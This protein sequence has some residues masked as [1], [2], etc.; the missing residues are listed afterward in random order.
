MKSF[1]ICFLFRKRLIKQE[2]DENIEKANTE[3]TKHK[4][5]SR[6]RNN[7]ESFKLLSLF[8]SLF[9]LSAHLWKPYKD[10][11][12]KISENGYIISLIFFFFFVLV[13]FSICLWMSC[14][15]HLPA[16]Y[17]KKKQRKFVHKGGIVLIRIE[18]SLFLNLCSFKSSRFDLCLWVCLGSL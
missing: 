13:S 4:K 12:L 2:K 10:L 18:I 17:R 5:Y 11:S 14:S 9:F 3:P 7:K 16:G 1:K 6:R 8:P 15:F